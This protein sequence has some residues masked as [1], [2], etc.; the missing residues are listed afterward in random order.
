MGKSIAI[1]FTVANPIIDINS[2][3]YQV[4]Q[5]TSPRTILTEECH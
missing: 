3:I 5:K 4:P 2:E 1:E